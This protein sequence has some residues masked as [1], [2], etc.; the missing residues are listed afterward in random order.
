MY[1]CPRSP[2]LYLAGAL[3]VNLQDV[4]GQPLPS[5]IG[6]RQAPLGC[7]CSGICKHAYSYKSYC[8]KSQLQGVAYAAVVYEDIYERATYDCES[9]GAAIAKAPAEVA[10]MQASVL[11]AVPRRRGRIRTITCQ[12]SLLVENVAFE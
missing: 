10:W 1:G 4:P 5:G 8:F 7:S 11:L 2:F 9:S 3:Q 6:L 12:A